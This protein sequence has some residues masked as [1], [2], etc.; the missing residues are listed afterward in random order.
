MLRNISITPIGI[1][2]VVDN[3]SYL[4]RLWRR[5][6]SPSDGLWDFF[7]QYVTKYMSHVEVLE[8]KK[9]VMVNVA[10][11]TSQFSFQ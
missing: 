8:G 9:L 2:I 5:D 10:S 3:N 6:Y 7:L 1:Q 11:A 4:P